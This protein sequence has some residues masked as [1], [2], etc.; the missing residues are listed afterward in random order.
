MT[1]PDDMDELLRRAMKTLDDQVPPGYFEGLPNRTL[2]RLEDSSMQPTP[3][4]SSELDSGST[5]VP[6]VEVGAEKE[7]DEDSGLHDIRNL[8]SSAR[9]RLSSRRI[10][11]HP[12]VDDDILASSSAGWKAVALP[13]PAKMIS[14]PEMAELPTKAEIK[15]KEKADRASRKSGEIAAVASRKSGEIAASTSAPAMPA[16]ASIEPPLQLEEPA[17]ASAVTPMIGSRITG[18]KKAKPATSTPKQGGSKAAVFGV[19][20][21][22][23]A[24]A[25]GVA[26]YVTTMKSNSSDETASAPAGERSTDRSV[27]VAAPTPAPAPTVQA[28]AIDEPAKTEPVADEGKQEP[29][30][31][32][33]PPKAPTKGKRDGKVDK[34]PA[35]TIIEVAPPP[36]T[37]TKKPPPVVTKAG[38]GKEGDPDFDALLKE[39]GV[40]KD[41]VIKPKLDKTSL[42][43]GDFKSGMNAVKGRAQACFN[44][45]QGTANVK[46]TIAPSGQVSKATVSGVFAG[47]PVAACVEAAVKGATF[48]AWDGG[49]QSFG[50]SYLLSE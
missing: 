13:E 20:G 26:I 3:G 31:A 32:A 16:I 6:P 30:V 40:S 50:Y 34:K 21:I 36:D 15:A 24:A 43:G 47:T 44:G 22:G 2:A 17:V 28:I 45:T 29:A 18:A 46:L 11:T 14:L 5:G 4:T 35:K 19:I 9:M 12:P 38:A 8:A 25:A 7:R 1:M 27:A 41:K 33:D 48:P 49:P 39:A 10:S 42:T 37:S 23:L